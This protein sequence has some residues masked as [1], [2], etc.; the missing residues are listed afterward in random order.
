[1]RRRFLCA[2]DSFKGSLTAPAA[3]AALACGVRRAAPDAEVE[4][5]PVADG[6]EG[7]VATLV[8]ATG[9]TSSTTATVDPL[10]RPIEAAWGL[11]GG[12]GPRTAVVEVAAA[13]GLTLLAEHERDPRRTSTFGTGLLIRAALDAGIDRLLLALGGSATHDSGCGA[14]QAL[15]IGFRDANGAVLREPVCGADLSRIAAIDRGTLDA[16]V[17]RVEVI[18]CR[19]VDSP[20]V[21]PDGAAFV[22]AR[23]KGADPSQLAALDQGLAHLAELW[24]STFGH[25][26]ADVR[27]AGAAGGMG[28]GMVAMLGAHSRPGIDVVLDALD[29]EE[30]LRGVSL[31]LTGEGRLDAQSRTGKAC[32]GVARRAHAAGVPVLVVTGEVAADAPRDAMREL[33]MT[34][35]ALDEGVSRRERMARAA[36]LVAAAAE[37]AVRAFLV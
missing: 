12:P 17:H 29:F 15:G 22:F 10:G 21:G 36:E 18:V 19:D 33:G 14:A 11:L 8:Q 28:G 5:C 25:D 30:R 31:C 34:A 9:G 6:G 27:G 35:I 7:T 3:A 4:S 32:F 20:L 16:R 1:M 2:P 37:R 13:S 26:L 24:R 23:Q